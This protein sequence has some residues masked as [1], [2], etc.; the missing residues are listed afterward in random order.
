MFGSLMGI[1]HRV[2]FFLFKIVYHRTLHAELIL[3]LFPLQR[4]CHSEKGEKK[5]PVIAR[6]H[7]SP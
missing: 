2:F 6:L 3:F 1:H 4:L 7:L 5:K